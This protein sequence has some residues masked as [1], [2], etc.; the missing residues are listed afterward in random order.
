M[1]AA[2]DL[3]GDSD[4]QMSFAGSG[5]ADQNDI[6]LVS[7]ELSLVKD[8]ILR[9]VDRRATEVERIQILGNTVGMES[10]SLLAVAQFC[11]GTL[12]RRGRFELRG[13]R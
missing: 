5:A 12:I 4:S 3:P 2:D 8:S 9:F 7:E 13:M 10:A 1:T 6:A 11:G